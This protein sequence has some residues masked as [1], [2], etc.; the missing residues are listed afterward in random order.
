VCLNRRSAAEELGL[1]AGDQVQ[2]AALDA[3]QPGATSV[4]FGRRPDRR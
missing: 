1:I 4:A 2:L 3:S